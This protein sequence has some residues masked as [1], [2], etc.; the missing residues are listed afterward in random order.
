M[1]LSCNSNNY[2]KTQNSYNLD[3]AK[4]LGLCY[5][6]KYLIQGGGDLYYPLC[7]DSSVRV[8]F[9]EPNYYCVYTDD[10]G[11]CGSCGCHLDIYRLEDNEYKELGICA[12]IGVDMQQPIKN[13]ILISDD[14]KTSSC[15]TY[16]KG[17]YNIKNEWLNLLEIVNYDHKYFGSKSDIHSHMDTCMYVDSLWLLKE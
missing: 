17:K 7:S 14:H 3:I 4:E 13:Y 8:F 2:K 16:Y 12:C 11:W 1:L 9:L 15:W 6:D 5:D 10:I